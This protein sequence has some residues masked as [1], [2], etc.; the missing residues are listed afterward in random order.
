[1]QALAAQLRDPADIRVLAALPASG[2]QALVTG[3]Q[4]LLALS[5]RFAIVSPAEF[6]ARHAP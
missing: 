1:M 6:C 3:D 4:D 5:G 2:A